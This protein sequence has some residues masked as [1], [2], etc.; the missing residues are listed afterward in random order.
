MALRRPPTTFSDEI[1]AADIATGAVDTAELAADAVDCTKIADNAIDSEHVTAGAVDTA[2]I[3]DDQVTYAKLQN[4]ATANRVLGATSTGLIGE[5]QVATA[6]V[7]DDAVT[8]AK[9][10]NNPTIA[11]NL[12]VAGTT[13]A[14]GNVTV[15]G[16]LIPSNTPSRNL[17]INGAMRIRQRGD[18]SSVGATTNIYSLDRWAYLFGYGTPAQRFTLSQ[19]TVSGSELVF[20]DGFKSVFY[21]QCTTAESNL[22][23]NVN[24]YSGIFQKI[25]YENLHHLRWGTSDAKGLTVSFWFKSTQGGSHGC[26]LFMN[27]GASVLPR[28]FSVSA[29]TWTKITLAIAANTSLQFTADFGLS[30]GFL[31][32]VGTTADNGTENTWGSFPAANSGIANIGGGSG[33]II[34]FTGVQLEVGS[35]TP[36]EHQSYGNELARCQR[37]YS[38]AFIGIQAGKANGST[39]MG[40]PMTV[41][42][43]MRATPAVS[44]SG[45][46]GF[47]RFNDTG[48]TIN[49]A[50][51]VAVSGSD[52]WNS[53]FYC[54]VT[55]ISGVTDNRGW[56]I[57]SSESVRFNAEL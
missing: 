54:N 29:N 28:T 1:S 7:A 36:F 49:N 42:V 35:A 57:Q 2:H 23:S 16:D 53:T 30:F 27:N 56:T 18:A 41:P 43:S 21:A 9:I 48:T 22:G 4:L 31:L 15:T 13:T 20:R 38:V 19:Q 50:T 17:L 14:T 8:G 45:T 26:C 47:S 52:A 5:V 11:G 37:Y 6:M 25:E 46:S 39:S 40:I 12:T 32:N 44:L 55:G 24:R 3:G 34:Q 33:R 51:G 10:E